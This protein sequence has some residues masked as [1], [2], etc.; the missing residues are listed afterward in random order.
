[1]DLRGIVYDKSNTESNGYYVGLMFILAGIN[2]SLRRRRSP[3]V[4]QGNALGQK[5][6]KLVEP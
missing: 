4:A 5:L 1:M 6:R 2:L 3:P